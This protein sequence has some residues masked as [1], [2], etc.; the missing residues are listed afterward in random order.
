MSHKLKILTS[1]NT[2]NDS[3]LEFFNFQHLVEGFQQS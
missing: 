1:E 2:L 3:N